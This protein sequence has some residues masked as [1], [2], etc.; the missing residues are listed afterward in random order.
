MASVQPIVPFP[1]HV[2][3]D[4]L[5]LVTAPAYVNRERIPYERWIRY[6]VF[7][8]DPTLIANNQAD[9][10]IKYDALHL[11]ELT[12]NRLY[13]RPD[14]DHLEPRYAVPLNEA[15]DTI[16]KI[17]LQLGH[18]G[19]N[20]VYDEIDRQF[21][22]IKRDECHWV[23]QH[24]VVCVLAAAQKSKPPL[25]AIITNNT[26][27]RVQIDL[28]DMRHQ[29]SGRFSWI[30]HVKDHFSKYTQLYPLYSKHAEGI[31]EAMAMFIM[32]FF[33]MKIL[34]CDNGKEFKGKTHVT[35]TTLSD[36][37]NSLI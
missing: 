24:C 4:F 31:A 22:G 28:I 14:R 7:L 25:T 30:L 9:R 33:P 36:F 26:F 13:R 20:K 17:H 21:Y 5:N 8:D 32:A 12:N 15:F 27:E 10:K 16:V 29:P 37:S 2:K 3:D 11:Y 35:S 1:P 6:K 19:R 34:Q 18:P 23:K